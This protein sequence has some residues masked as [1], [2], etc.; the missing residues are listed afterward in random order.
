[1][2]VAITTDTRGPC[3][4]AGGLQR[5][6]V[7]RAALERTQ[8]AEH[9]SCSAPD[10]TSCVAHRIAAEHRGDGRINP[11]DTARPL[12]QRPTFVL[13]DPPAGRLHEA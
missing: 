8:A 7:R 4:G 3:S 2:C 9:A 13:R 12:E 5:L 10:E 11:H 6:A 1:M